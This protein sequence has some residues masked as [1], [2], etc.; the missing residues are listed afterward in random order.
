MRKILLPSALPTFKLIIP[1]AWHSHCFLNPINIRLVGFL[2]VGIFQTSIAACL[3]LSVFEKQPEGF[4]QDA[5]RHVLLLVGF[6]FGVQQNGRPY[7]SFALAC[8]K[9]N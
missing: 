7:L 1:K 8:N 9:D 5:F 2:L 6:A 3:S 4:C